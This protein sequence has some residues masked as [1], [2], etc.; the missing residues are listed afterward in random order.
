[1]TWQRHSARNAGLDRLDS[2]KVIH[3]QTFTALL[4]VGPNPLPS[5]GPSKGSSKDRSRSHV[6]HPPARRRHHDKLGVRDTAARLPLE[7]DDSEPMDE[8]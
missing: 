2:E 3:K 5:K 8:T 7:S 4:G 6:P 1:M